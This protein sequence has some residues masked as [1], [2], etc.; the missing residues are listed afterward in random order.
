MVFSRTTSAIPPP[1]PQQPHHTAKNQT[2]T[3]IQ[4]SPGVLVEY[5]EF[6]FM[7]G[8]DFCLVAGS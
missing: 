4:L 8:D 1:H 3:V 7:F 2:S 6:V 5:A